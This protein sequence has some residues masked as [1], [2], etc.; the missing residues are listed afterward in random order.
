MIVWSQSALAPFVKQQHLGIVIDSLNDLEQ[1]IN[2]LP[3][4]EYQQM[5]EFV[6]VTA[7]QLRNGHSIKAAVAQIEERL[8]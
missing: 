1:V 4:H 6:T 2:Q 7:D 8:D 5:I 3:D